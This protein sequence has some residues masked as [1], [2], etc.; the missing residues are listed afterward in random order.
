MPRKQ[1]IAYALYLT[2]VS[3]GDN[4][5]ETLTDIGFHVVDGN[6]HAYLRIIHIIVYVFFINIGVIITESHSLNILCQHKIEHLV[7][8]YHSLYEKQLIF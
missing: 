8:M 7:L 3:L 2:F 6:N 4:G 1:L 5:R